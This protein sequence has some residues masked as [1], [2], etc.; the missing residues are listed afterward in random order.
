[1]PYQCKDW[2]PH[3]TVATIVEENG[4]FLCV[5]EL[6]SNGKAV[7]NQPAGHVERGESIVEAAVRETLEETGYTVE[8]QHVIAIQRWH[9]SHSNHTY[10]RFVISAKTIT[11]NKNL[12]LDEGII[13]THWLSRDDFTRRQLQLRSDLVY[14]TI[15]TYLSGQQFPLSLLQDFE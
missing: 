12:E 8:P 15:D 7:I 11:Y 4:K 14:K 10:F 2:V 6:S 9:K 13:R 3:I 1:M 5:E